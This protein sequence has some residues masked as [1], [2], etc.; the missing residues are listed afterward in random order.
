[1]AELAQ[2]DVATL[3]WMTLQECAR[4]IKVDV[5]V[6]R[7]WCIA[8]E[9]GDAAG[10]PSSHFGVELDES[11]AKRRNRRVHID[12]WKAFKASRRNQAAQQERTVRRSFERVPRERPIRPSA[13]SAAQG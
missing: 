7:R 8:H 5:E 11:K 2:K 12:D 6:I 4:E 13:I 3:E 1:M 9:S 10:L